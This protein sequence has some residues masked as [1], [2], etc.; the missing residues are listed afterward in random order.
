LRIHT[1]DGLYG[2][3]HV[4]RGVIVKDLVDRRIRDELL[5]KTH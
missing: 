2:E 5:G 1:D 3:A 4:R